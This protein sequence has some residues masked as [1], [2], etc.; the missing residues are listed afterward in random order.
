VLKLVPDASEPL[1]IAARGQ[2]IGRWTIPR[3]RYPMDRIGYLRW[4]EDLKKFHA[5]KVAELMRR[6]GY[7]DRLIERTRSIILK[8]NFKTDPEAQTIEDALC[9]I[10]LETQLTDLMHK[11][12]ADKMLVIIQKTWA[13][14]SPQGREA[15]LDIHFEPEAGELIRQALSAKPRK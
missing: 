9:L 11:T 2:H 7:A 12:P 3:D 4:R 1:R 6:A 13:K 5:E 14:M 15:A 10:F 8:K